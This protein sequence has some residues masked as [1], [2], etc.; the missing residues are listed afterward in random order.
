M[1]TVLQGRSSSQPQASTRGMMRGTAA[2]HTNPTPNLHPNLNHRQEGEEEKPQ[3]RTGSRASPPCPP[4]S[5]QGH[6]GWSLLCPAP[7]DIVPTRLWDTPEPAG[8]G[9]TPN[10]PAPRAPRRAWDLLLPPR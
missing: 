7:V 9:L 4:S 1:G 8:S 3:G 6:G 2:A 5:L 10:P